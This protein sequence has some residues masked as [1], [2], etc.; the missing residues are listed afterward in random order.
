MDLIGSYGEV[1]DDE[2]EF[3][4]EGGETAAVTDENATGWWPAPQKCCDF[5]MY[6]KR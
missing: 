6:R 2:M 4:P 1:S 3:I 5:R